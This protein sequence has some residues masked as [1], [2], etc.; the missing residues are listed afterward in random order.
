MRKWIHT[1]TVKTFRP[2]AR[3]ALGIGVV[4]QERSGTGPRGPIVYQVSE[5]AFV[6]SQATE[7][8]AILR[9]FEVAV[10]QGYSR[11][12]IRTDAMGA[13]KDIRATRS[14]RRY[15]LDRTRSRICEL[16]DYFIWVGFS[17][18]PARKN[19]LALRLA[20]DACEEG[21]DARRN[22]PIGSLIDDSA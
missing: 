11:I 19:R 16:I 13:L 6:H 7:V 10:E 9:A 15:E 3:D 17:F 2:S 1:L 21:G 22:C 14:R 4:V 12:N 5:S 18:V 8:F 20:K